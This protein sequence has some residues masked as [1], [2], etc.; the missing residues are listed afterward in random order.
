MFGIKSETS[1]ITSYR[2]VSSLATKKW[3][4]LD[5]KVAPKYHKITTC[6]LKHN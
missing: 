4:V 1:L 6:I 2:K 5:P 3:G